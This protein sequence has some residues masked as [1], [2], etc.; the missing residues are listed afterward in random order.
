MLQIAGSAALALASLQADDVHFLRSLSKAELHA[1]LNGSIPINTILELAQQYSPSIAHTTVEDKVVAK[2]IERLK[3]GVS[4]DEVSDFFYL[5]PAIYALTS[6]PQALQTATCVVLQSFLKDDGTNGP[7]CTYLELRTT[8]RETP[9]MTREDYLKTVLMEMERYPAT[10]A[11]LIVSVDRRMSDRDI[12]ECVNLAI[13]FKNS[14]RRVVGIDLCGDPLKGDMQIFTKHILRAKEAGLGLTVHI[15]ETT[16]NTPEESQLLLSW[17]PD[18]LGHATFLSEE[19]KGEF[20]ADTP[21]QTTLPDCDMG[22]TEL[23]TRAS[24]ANGWYKPC[25]EICLSSNLLCKS[26]LS[27]DAHHIH[28]YLKNDHPVVICTDDVLPFRTSCLGEYAL[29]L[30]Q[31][32]LGLGLDRK[33]VERL[34][35]MGMDAAFLRPRT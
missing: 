19:L 5:F 10:Q 7:Q 8:P 24:D 34:A 30:A 25:I 28:D 35:K 20:F 17:R 2:T 27:L 14:G 15:A 6:T 33:D 31:R 12:E 1:H 23:Q 18:R 3:S 16:K 22:I 9:H 21:Q 29:L 11:A 32:P 4:L 13:K 26:V